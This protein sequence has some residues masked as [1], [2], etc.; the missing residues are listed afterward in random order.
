MADRDRGQRGVLALAE[1]RTG[2]LTQFLDRRP[3]GRVMA[4]V[5]G[6]QQTDVRRRVAL[7]KTPHGALTALQ[8]AGLAVLLNQPGELLA[9]SS[10]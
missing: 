3:A 7:R 5:H 2:P 1:D 10:R 9:G 8:G 6:G 4:F